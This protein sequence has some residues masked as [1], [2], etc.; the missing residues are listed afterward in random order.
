MT[1]ST[2]NFIDGSITGSFSKSADVLIENPLVILRKKVDF[3]Q[4][5]LDAGEG[6]VAQCLAI[7]ARTTVVSALLRVI[8]VGAVGT[9]VNLGYGVDPDYWGVGLS[10]ENTGSARKTITGSTTW[11][12]SSI[13]DA[14]T[15]DKEVTVTG[16]EVGDA[17]TV[18]LSI[19]LGGLTISGEV[20]S[21]NT[22]TATL[23]NATGEAVDLASATLLAAAY[24]DIGF[25]EPVYFASADTI[26]ITAT[27]LNGDINITEGE[28]EIVALCINH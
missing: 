24:K 4:Q 20:T 12:A 17:V 25:I 3:S 23:T 10:L 22:V 6:D 15:E 21:A 2:Y 28:V 16:A 5:S 1:A 14:G 11:D 27:T 13:A 8:S 9:T 19:A 18:R 26:D 7:P